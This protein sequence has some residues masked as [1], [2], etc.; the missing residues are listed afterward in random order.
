V[1]KWV[2]F[3]IRQ[4]A[5]DEKEREVKVGLEMVSEPGKECVGI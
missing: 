3:R 1:A 2:E 4:R 5:S